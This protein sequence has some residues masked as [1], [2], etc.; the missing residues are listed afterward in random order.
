MDIPQDTIVHHSHQQDHTIS[1]HHEH[2]DLRGHKDNLHEV[3]SNHPNKKQK[4]EQVHVGESMLHAAYPATNGLDL[5]P[6]L[7]P[8]N[9]SFELKDTND[10]RQYLEAKFNHLETKITLLELRYNEEISK[11]KHE[12]SILKATASG[13]MLHHVEENKH[14]VL[15]DSGSISVH[16]HPVHNVSIEDLLKVKAAIEGNDDVE[17]KHH[18]H[19]HHAST[20]QTDDEEDEEE[21]EEDLDDEMDGGKNS[22]STD[23]AWM[24]R[25]KEIKK[26][27]KL[28][29][30]RDPNMTGFPRFDDRPHLS[31]WLNQQVHLKKT[32][33]LSDKRVKML[34]DI[35]FDFKQHRNLKQH[36]DIQFDKL[37]K[38]KDQY[39][40]CQLPPDYDDEV[41]R[42]WINQ[43]RM[44][45]N[46]SRPKGRVAQEHFAK[47][48]EI[49]FI[50]KPPKDERRVS[51]SP[52]NTSMHHHHHQ[53]VVAD[54][55]P[56]VS[57]STASI[58]D[59]PQ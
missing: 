24:K 10:V 27:L 30:Q 42:A 36:W 39:G 22:P 16:Q 28:Y 7:P 52:L 38:I 50:W 35:E 9:S 49:G 26:L 51:N 43:Q 41:L 29:K 31:K 58:S 57:A 48:D 23:K 8:I 56:V 40:T 11:L 54:G 4:L 19:Q 15:I 25:Y 1:L 17:D 59:A 12:I 5:N 20:S 18:H 33:K 47:L 55:P 37:K 46:R 3:V 53:V 34:H 14:D 21:G 44:E 6:Q 13:H 45:R 32:G 2:I